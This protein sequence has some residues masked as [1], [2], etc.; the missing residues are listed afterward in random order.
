MATVDYALTPSDRPPS[1]RAIRRTAD[2][3]RRAAEITPGDIVAGRMLWHRVAVPGWQGL[4]EAKV[5]P[6]RDET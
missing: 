5:E 3:R 2:E 6:E 1:G 4:V